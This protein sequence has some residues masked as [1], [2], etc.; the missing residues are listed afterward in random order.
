MTTDS[1]FGNDDRLKKSVAPQSRGSRSSA[2]AERENKDGTALSIDE[3]KRMLRQSMVNEVL[4][5]P[6]QPKVPGWHY[7]WLSTTNQSDPIFKRLQMGYE[8]VKASEMPRFGLQNKVPSGEFEGCIAVNEMI[9][10]KI[11]E[12]LFQEIM[13]INHHEK[14]MEEEEFLKAN[15]A[16]TQQDSHGNHLGMRE[17]FE[18]LGRRVATPTF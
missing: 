18:T 9:L 17:G 13:L 10:S 3:R 12:E 11:P 4:P 16:P 2:D 5:D 6:N 14:P 8:L 15:A 1:I 7:C